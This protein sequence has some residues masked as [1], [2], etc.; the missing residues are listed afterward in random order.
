MHLTKLMDTAHCISLRSRGLGR[1]RQKSEKF[2]KKA[3]S[4]IRACKR[5]IGFGRWTFHLLADLLVELEVVDS[6]SHE[7]VGGGRRLPFAKALEIGAEQSKERGFG[8]FGKAEI[9]GQGRIPHS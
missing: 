5:P 7:T 6:I 9:R 8:S 1:V 4:A 2:S 3:S